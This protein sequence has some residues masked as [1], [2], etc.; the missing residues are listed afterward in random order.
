MR[1]GDGGVLL[2]ELSHAFHNKFCPNGFDC[3]EIEQLFRTAMKANIYHKVHVHG[4][5]GKDGRLCKHYACTNSMEFWAELSVAYHWKLDGVTE[6]N[7][8]YPFNNSQLHFHDPET[9][10]VLDKYWKQFE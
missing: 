5:Q 10:A 8:W 7:K 4:S 2:H 9:W 3:A 1:R 6:Y